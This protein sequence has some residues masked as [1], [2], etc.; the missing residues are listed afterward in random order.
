MTG[1]SAIGPNVDLGIKPDLT[2][3]GSDMYVATQTADPN[4]DMYSADGYALVDGTSFSTPLVAGALALLKS[5]RPGLT[6]AQYRSLLVD[7][8]TG[9]GDSAGNGATIQETGG[10]QLNLGAA[11]RSMAAAEPSSLSL[12]AAGTASATLRIENLGADT[13][14]YSISVEPSDGGAAPAPSVSSLEVAAGQGG[15]VAMTL[16][17]S[18]LAAGAYQGIVRITGTTSGTEIRVPYW[19]GVAGRTPATIP[20]LA[21][22]ITGRRSRQVIDAFQ[23][24]VTDSAGVPIAGVVPDVSVT[25]GSGTVVSVASVDAD[26]PG[27]FSVTVRL[28]LEAGVNTFRI[29]AGQVLRDVNITAQ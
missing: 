11:L 22:T 13:E 17:G 21:A 24:R 15:D 14:T 8:A 5:A 10:G 9:V 25:A 19:F 23:F 20:L 16:D 12:G 2:A 18:G 29:Q 4:G 6:A 7:T 28:G 26:S 3:V 1:F 27:V